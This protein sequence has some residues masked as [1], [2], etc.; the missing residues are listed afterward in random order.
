MTL[1]FFGSEAFMPHGYCYLWNPW[2]V[3]LHILSDSFI[4]IANA[5][6]NVFTI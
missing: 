5:P 6:K 4:A 3:W 1:A 2:L